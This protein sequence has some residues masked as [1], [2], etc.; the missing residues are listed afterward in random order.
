MI[1]TLGRLLFS[2]SLIALAATYLVAFGGG[3]EAPVLPPGGP[4]LVAA[5]ALLLA[6]GGVLILF[7]SSR[8]WVTAGAA[9]LLAFLVPATL[10]VHVWAL[11][12]PRGA[13][14]TE[15]ERTEHVMAFLK[16]T[17]LA[18]ACLV[19]ISYENKLHSHT[20]SRQIP[21]SQQLTE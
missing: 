20:L 12:G 8:V 21:A 9:S 17:S 7:S 10:A 2:V 4:A 1:G 16:N 13:L 18:G 11:V 3:L 15:A 6:A 5:G 14:L 19:L